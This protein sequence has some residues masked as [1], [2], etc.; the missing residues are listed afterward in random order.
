MIK[1]LVRILLGVMLLL[2]LVAAVTLLIEPKL[3][4]TPYRE[5][6]AARLSA[7]VGREVRL[8]GDIRASLGRHSRITLGDVRIAN[9]TWA[10]SR[11]LLHAAHLS[12]GIDWFALSS[13]VVHVEAVTLRDATIALEVSKDGE[14]SWVLAGRD[15]QQAAAPRWSG[16]W[17]F[18]VEGAA[19]EDVSML[20]R[21]ADS[22]APVHMQ[23]DRLSQV[24]DDATL[25]LDGSGRLETLAFR[26]G[27]RV[28]PLHSLLEGR[29]IDVDL[30]A[31]MDE[32]LMTLRGHLG[33]PA[34]LEDIDLDATIQGSGLAG[35]LGALGIRYPQSGEADLRVQLSDR[36]AG[37]S[38]ES[39]GHLGPMQL[40]TRGR[41]GKPLD[42]DDLRMTVDVRGQDLAL[43]GQLFGEESL[44]SQAYSL[45]G[46][47]LRDARG[48]ELRDVELL[49]GDSRLTLS[50]R[51]PSYPKL[52][53]AD[54]RIEV[55]LPDP[56]PFAGLIGTGIIVTDL[57]A[58]GPLRANAA[59]NSKA[60][61]DVLLDAELGLG[62]NRLSLKGPLGNPPDYSGSRLEFTAAGPDFSALHGAFAQ[63]WMR[64]A[65][66]S[67]GGRLLVDASGGLILQGAQGKA[68]E[69]NVSANGSVGRLPEMDG[70][71]L[72]LVLSGDSL[73]RV[74]GADLPALPFT[75][76]AHLLDKLSAP[77]IDRV[78]ARLGRTTLEATGR[79]GLP[80]RFAGS[81][82][83]LSARVPDLAELVPAAS[84]S[85]WAGGE[86]RLG[87]RLRNE[88]GVLRLDDFKVDSDK[89]NLTLAANVQAV[90]K[91][92][93][94]SDM[95]ALL[96]G[97]EIDGE[98][99]FKPRARPYLDMD[100]IVRRIDVTPWLPVAAPAGRAEPPEKVRAGA[101]LIPDDPLAL[102]FLD[103][104][105]GHFRVAGEDLSHPDPVF[106]GRLLARQLALDAKLND[107]NLAVDHLHIV[108]DR[109]EF[110]LKGELKRSAK[111]MVANLALDARGVR[112]GVLARGASLQ[113]LPQHDLDAQFSAYG[114]SARDLASSLN[115]ELRLTGGR[116]ETANA[117][118]DRMFGSFGAELLREVNPFG[119][120]EASTHIECT[121]AALQVIGGIVELHPGFV[122]RTDKMDIA[123]VGTID[124]KTEKIDVHFHNAPRQGIGI[125]AAGLVRPYVKVGGSL[126]RPTL[127][128]DAPGVLLHGGVAV[129]T[130]GLSIV[131]R[132]MLDRLSTA[133]DPCGQVLAAESG[134]L[135][136]GVFQPIESLRRVLSGKP[137]GS[138]PAE[139]EGQGLPSLPGRGP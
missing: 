131:A 106:P 42:M 14:R 69:L 87:G 72:S 137:S 91:G 54:A 12:A 16:R 28:G 62:D 59:L 102:P 57:A 27:G 38:W 26:L 68:G 24:N 84:G 6:L 20:Y 80:P 113:S 55:V 18:V 46:D 19:I 47:V 118:L 74:A 7:L 11:D 9:P 52:D 105:D 115:G 90:D 44:P 127:M 71:D 5:S 65:S 21:A 64:G 31:G 23:I 100:V 2:I 93:R 78:S 112:Y 10:E 63:A 97:G 30:H 98:I 58:L 103:A 34:A 39:S 107:G 36:D 121:A 22:H 1:W 135:K 104:L 37:F 70:A 92:Y 29:N 133:G 123:A 51:L 95:R 108:G 126:A 139:V 116:G 81:D 88:K 109:G 136:K 119:K 94:V 61:N 132:H 32:L 110:T 120:R 17:R 83:R 111:G 73:R 82:V 101:R 15:R 35:L 79:V 129:A 43:L 125:S 89:L 25:V 75:V 96:N 3:D 33:E 66:F 41:V 138:R 86:Y 60:R 13:G 40:D 56:K 67:L 128:V 45:K 134:Q 117:G 85:R 130:A 122:T 124:L 114:R 50:G 53:D 8:D 99:T 76:E 77:A 4:L 49:S 48:L